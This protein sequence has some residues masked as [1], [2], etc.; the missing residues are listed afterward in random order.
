MKILEVT[1]IDE[2]NYPGNIGMMEMA[3]FYQVATQ[4]QKLHMKSL[5]AQQ[6]TEEAW[7]FL[8]EVSKMQLQDK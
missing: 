6:K 5:I 2:L 8:Q 4:E 1:Q 3:R 7:K